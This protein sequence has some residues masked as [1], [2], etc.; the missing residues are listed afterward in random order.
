LRVSVYFLTSLAF[1]LATLAVM[2]EDPPAGPDRGSLVIVGGGRL[3]PEI[4]ERFLELAGGVDAPIVVVPT[5]GGRPAYD[6]DWRGAEFLRKA[7]ATDLTILHTY[8]RVEADSDSFVES[9]R[10]ASAVWFSGGRQWRLVDAYAGTLAETEFHRVL[11]RGGVIGG[12]SAGATIQGSY[13]VRGAPEGS[14]IMMAEGHEE[15]FGFVRGVAI[16]QHWMARGRENDLIEV[17]AAHPELLGFGID[18]STALIVRGNRVEIIGASYVGLYD[19]KTVRGRKGLPYRL[20]SPGDVI[21]LALPER[22]EPSSAFRRN[23]IESD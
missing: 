22:E 9:I 12:S 16:D 10:R 7:G 11:E 21:D 2:A 6:A 18:E 20:F 13:L 14:H 5:A 23:R 1:L 15:G 17:I 3:G 8:D 19:W 4:V